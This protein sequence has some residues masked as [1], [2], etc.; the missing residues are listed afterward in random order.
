MSNAPTF[1][2]LSVFCGIF[3]QSSGF[4]YYGED[5]LLRL[6]LVGRRVCLAHPP[7]RSWS[8]IPCGAAALWGAV[9]ASS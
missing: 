1:I 9:A 2:V 4:S 3:P 7:S 8:L 5:L 6:L